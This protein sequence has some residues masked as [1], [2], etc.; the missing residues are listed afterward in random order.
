LQFD[1]HGNICSI[2]PLEKGKGDRTRIMS[3]IP[4]RIMLLALA[5]ASLTLADDQGNQ[6]NDTKP[7]GRSWELR[8]SKPTGGNRPTANISYHG[9][10][11]ILGGTNVYVIW[12][13]NWS[14]NTAT[15]ILQSFLSSIGGSPY[16]NINTTYYSVSGNTKHPVTNAVTFKGF[17]N[18]NYSQGTALSDAGVQ[19]V[20]SLA[21]SNKSLPTDTNGVY[22]V[23]T[24][25]DVDETSGFC[26]RYC[27][28]HTAATIAGSDIKYSF[29]G[30]PD[31]CP[32]A[33]S[34]QS[35]RPVTQPHGYLQQPPLALA[36]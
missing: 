31:R 7:N 11:V 20:V 22:F 8:D 32:S 4:F 10:P 12:Y 5:A 34:A 9:G 24:S 35:S 25:A 6:G 21:L 27:G 19:A 16:F 33:C 29:V 28:W 36:D 18:D 15:T 17:T 23:L 1:P 3:K 30:N 13:G 26:T 14:G 2:G